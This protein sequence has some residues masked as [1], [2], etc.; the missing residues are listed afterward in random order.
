MDMVEQGA[1]EEQ[2]LS[3]DGE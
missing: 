1:L 2:T 3:R